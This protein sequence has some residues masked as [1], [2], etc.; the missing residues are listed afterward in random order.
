MLL[1]LL[2]VGIFVGVLVRWVLRLK[3]TT[4]PASPNAD[5]IPA[6]TFAGH[7]PGYVFTTRDGKT[8]YYV[9]EDPDAEDRPS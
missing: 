1:M 4:P 8:G 2:A 6:K 3:D 7:K 5:F 9:D